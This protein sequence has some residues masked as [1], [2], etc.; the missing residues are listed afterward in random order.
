MDYCEGCKTQECRSTEIYE[1]LQYISDEFGKD[2]QI[3]EC[4]DKAG[5][6]YTCDMVL[7]DKATEEKYM[8]KL[9]FL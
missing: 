8:L 7:I 2:F 3:C 4:P 6:K 5:A 1:F 9:V